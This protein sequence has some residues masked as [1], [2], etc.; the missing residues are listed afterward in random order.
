[1]SETS[2]R[3][4]PRLPDAEIRRGC[5]DIYTAPDVVG[6]GLGR[7]LYGRLF[8]ALRG[9]DLHRLVAGIT[10]PND[11][12]VHLHERMGFERVG[13]FTANG[14]KFGRY[15]DVAWYERPAP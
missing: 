14:R 9:A 5:A 4:A 8:E 15:H 6:R 11:H 13:V 12:S 2:G 3:A 7:R 1:M 10:L